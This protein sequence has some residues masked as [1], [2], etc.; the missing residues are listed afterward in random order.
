MPKVSVIIPTHNRSHMLPY[1][2][3][4]AFNAGTDVEVIVVDDASTDETSEACKFLEGIRY[5]RME[6]NVG[7][8][9]ARNQGIR[10]SVADYLAFLD[11]D[12]L[13]LPDSLDFQIQILEENPTAAFAYGPVYLMNAETKK[14][15]TEY[16]PPHL[17][18]G[19]VFE[20][21]VIG[22]FIYVPSVVVRRSKLLEVGEFDR[23]FP[24]VEDW[25]LWIRLAEKYPVVAVEKAVAIYRQASPFSG[26]ATSSPEEMSQIASKVQDRALTLPRIANASLEYQRYI[27][28]LILNCQVD[29]SIW[30]ANWYLENQS[31]AIAW[32]ILTGAIKKAPFRSI[33][34]WTL[35]LLIRSLFASFRK[36]ERQRDNGSYS[37]KPS[38]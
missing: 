15:T 30:R 29:T 35:Q 18:T 23:R 11:D 27:R 24:M 13:R 5:L 33:R 8:A 6:R 10:A 38:G 9:T 22:N 14:V 4:S 1:A 3:E 12:D 20:K 17:V 34:P 26:Q 21:L 2:V 16:Y 36:V 19:D 25:D 37:T 7:L 32:K 31:P 28:R